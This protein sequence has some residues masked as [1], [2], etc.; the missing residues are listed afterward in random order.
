[1]I[2][3]GAA[4]GFADAG[5]VIAQTGTEFASNYGVADMVEI[6]RGRWELGKRLGQEIE[7]GGAG[8][9]KAATKDSDM[10]ST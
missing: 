3:V 9:L 6:G 7:V 8:W 2:L 1:V 4:A 10:A 5:A